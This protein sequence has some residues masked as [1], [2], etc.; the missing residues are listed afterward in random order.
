MHLYLTARHFDLTH[1]IRQRV[2]EHLLRPVA[3][4]VDLHELNRMEVQLW[5]A[6]RDARYG[7]H[8]LVQLP[9][10]RARIETLFHAFR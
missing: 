4:H 2:E 10:N 6:Q 1:A 7:C 9:E 5:V 3:S 8:A